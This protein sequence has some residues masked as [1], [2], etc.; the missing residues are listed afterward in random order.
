MTNTGKLLNINNVSGD[1]FSKLF[2]FLPF[3]FCTKFLNHEQ[4]RKYQT[5][6]ANTGNC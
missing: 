3:K 4:R 2:L 6:L 1:F 5:S